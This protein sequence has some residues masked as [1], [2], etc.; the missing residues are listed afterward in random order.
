MVVT[1]KRDK[2]VF[3]GLESSASVIIAILSIIPVFL[4]F[5]KKKPDSFSLDQSS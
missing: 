5:A 4:L 2:A 1:R 3:T